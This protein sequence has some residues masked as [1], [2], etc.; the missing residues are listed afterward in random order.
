MAAESEAPEVQTAPTGL[1]DPLQETS[2]LFVKVLGRGAFGEAVLYRKTEDN[3]LVVWKEVNLARLGEKERRDAMKEVDIL[4]L[5]NN[6]NVI[7]YYNHFL[8]MDTLFIEM[9]YANGGS[10][11]EKISTQT[12]L[13]P[14]QVVRWYLFQITSALMHIHN[15]GIIH[16][17]VKAMNIFMTKTDLLKLGDFGI[18]K[19]LESKGQM[20]DTLVGTPYYLSPEIVQG[21]SYDQKTDVWALGCVLFEL[22]TLTKTFQ[23]TNQLRLA[24]E[25]VQSKQGE[26]DECYSS[27]MRELV[28]LM[29]LKDPKKR[30]STTNILD[31]PVFT[32]DNWSIEKQVWELNSG[33]RKLRLQSASSVET[34]PVI[35]SKVTEVYQWG[36]GKRTPQKQDLFVK[37]KS[38]IQVAAGGAHFAV[39]TMEKELYT[40]ANVQGG[41][42]IAG[43]LG[44]GNKS[45]YKAPKKVEALEGVGIIQASCG[46]DFTLSVTDEGQVY[47]FG[48]D[49]YGCLGCDNE[50]GDEVLVPILVDYFNTRPVAEVSCGQCHVMALTRDTEVYSWGCGEFG[51]L[52]LGSEDDF[53]SPQ[54]VETPGKHFIKHVY[55]GSDGTFLVTTSG[56]VLACGSN[57]YNKLGF[58]SETSGLR[59]QKP[60]I[61]DIPCKYTFSTVKPLLRFNIVLVSAG[62]THSA[63]V[64]LYG[65]VY[66][67]GSNKYGQLGVGD[68]KKKSGIC[69]VA[70]ALTGKR[71]INVTC[72]SYFTVAATNDSQVYSWGNGANGTLGAE[73]PDQGKGP[74][75]Q[76]ISLPRTIFGSL[77]LVSNLSSHHWHTIAIAEKVLN[78]KTLKSRV[79]SPKYEKDLHKVFLPSPPVVEEDALF[80]ES[81]GISKPKQ[82]MKYLGNE[83]MK[84]SGKPDSPE[85][86]EP[87][88][89]WNL[90]PRSTPYIPSP[91]LGAR[92]ST[93]QDSGRPSSGGSD[94]PGSG[95]K[96]EESNIPDWLQAELEDADFIPFCSDALPVSPPVQYPGQPGGPLVYADKEEMEEAKKSMK[97]QKLLESKEETELSQKD[98]LIAFLKQKLADMESENNL[99]KEQ[100]ASQERRMKSLETQMGEARVTGDQ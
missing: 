90:P 59:K 96:A 8:D 40:W 63:G 20:A 47:A 78:Q 75:G 19:L 6:T 95:G 29:L 10:L 89:D 44:Q 92:P 51:R 65:K 66:T 80:V 27:H 88:S 53:A 35:K 45:A 68:F 91:V 71:V 1:N 11:Y 73:F 25:I 52:G 30:P 7:T 85:V 43:Q 97:E 83:E 28:N 57:E 72:G 61:Y 34:V 67:F 98:E 55:A 39:V 69:R 79:S 94:R 24:Y 58:N 2:Y 70:G 4:S 54:K 60:K 99:L 21:A 16:R 86:S 36:G 48:S 42:Q 37:G 12:E 100:L 32:A 50:E 49:Y 18:S 17:D 81:D 22:L 56:R 82:C 84:D 33:A 62:H 46:D 23:A 38:A 26:V 15:Y 9:E 41:A 13:F 14:E 64:D 87:Q 5:L 77:H 76:S 74:N 3:S 93:Y 31:H